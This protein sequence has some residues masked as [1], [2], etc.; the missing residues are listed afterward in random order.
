[1]HL[2]EIAIVGAG[3]AGAYCAA[4]LAVEGFRPVLFD[5]SHPR[6]K[7]C[8]GGLSPFAQDAFPFLREL[9]FVHG[10]TNLI[11]IVYLHDKSITIAV[12][13]KIIIAS[14]QRLDQ[15]ILDMAVSNGARLEREKVIGVMKCREG[16]KVKTGKSLHKAGILVG[17]DGVHSVVRKALIGSF[18]AHDLGICFGYIANPSTSEGDQIISLRFLPERKGYIWVFPRGVDFCIGVGAEL[19]RSF[20]LKTDLDRFLKV[21]CPHLELKSQW[22]ALIPNPRSEALRKRTAG[23]DWALIGD[24]AGHVESIAGEGIPYALRSAELASEALSRNNL[25]LY[26]SYWREEYGAFL[27][28]SAKMKN[29]IFK[30]YVCTPYFLLTSL[31]SGR[32]TKL[33]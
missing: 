26:D 25:E 30:R 27:S 31:M 32:L 18:R 28:Y 23:A 9:T 8:G 15:Y 14:R 21:H 17:A 29:V 4:S 20:G 5:H 3:P 22:A 7:A 10:E 6:E 13:R 33:S 19:G 1:L 16:W 24:A 2:I 11:R 12:K